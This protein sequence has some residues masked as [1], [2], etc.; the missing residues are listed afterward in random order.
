MS[1][2]NYVLCEVFYS[3]GETR[4]LQ[5][6]WLCKGRKE[7]KVFMRKALLIVAM[8]LL[9]TPV[10]ATTTITAVKDGAVF[11]LDNTNQQTVAIRYTTT[12]DVRAFALYISIDPGPTFDSIR[13]FNIGEANG[14][15]PGGK[16][17]YGIFPSRFRDFI[18]VTN[19]A[20]WG[21]GNYN[22]TTAWNEPG[23]TDHT[24]GM[25]WPR[26]IVEMGT[27][28][29]GVAN[30]PAQSGTLFRFDV[31][32]EHAHGT[33]NLTIAADALRGGVV[34]NDGVAITG[35][36]LVFV[37]AAIDFPCTV[38]S[39][40]DQA[41]A[42]ATAAITAAG[43]TLGTRTTAGNDSIVAGNVI[44]TT[45]AANAEPGCSTAVAYKV[46]TGPCVVPNVVN[47]AEATATTNITNAGFAL[48][49]RTTSCDAS[50]VAGNVI[51]TTP[52]NPATPG[53][54]TA[55]AYLVSL[56]PVMTAPASCTVP[57]NDADGSYVV[58]WAAVT[59]ATS[60]QLESSAPASGITV[61]PLWVQIYSGP[62]VTFTEKVGGGTWSYRVKATNACS[63]SGSGYTAGNQNCVVAESLKAAA[64]GYADWVKYR[65]PQCWGFR[66][67][68]HGDIDG[69]K[70]LVG[71]YVSTDDLA[72][73][74]SVYT[75][76]PAQIAAVP[77]TVATTGRICGFCADLDHKNKLVGGRVSTDDLAIFK[78]YYTQAD[79][80]VTCCDTAAPAND[81]V[82]VAG[83]PFNYWTN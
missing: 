29:D 27:L 23:T 64:T 12:V 41:E 44:S 53:C 14:A 49:A 72:I 31:N 54:G 5:S 61:Y 51:S 35:A 39:V 62:A 75:L 50:I 52:A 81:C 10:M 59:G 9:V 25:G 48:G 47:Q 16:S 6:V 82:L 33:Y 74:K 55:V 30:K 22:P 32:S 56:G 21:D 24:Y 45:P 28:Y 40:V 20:T 66:R 38:P 67:Q 4:T 58:S 63:P 71:G 26:M 69:K 70:K 78:T 3:A 60:Y 43:F 13:D 65:Y 17:G 42:T 8:L 77:C 19:P 79:A 73:F 2:R 15:T 34:N 83:D 57:A 36:D 18:V 80:V 7:R 37:P 1:G 11:K 46:S 76:T 68:C